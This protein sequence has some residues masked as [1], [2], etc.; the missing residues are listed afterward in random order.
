[1]SDLLSGYQSNLTVFHYQE[2]LN[3]VKIAVQ[4]GDYGGGKLF[5]QNSAFQLQEQGRDFSSLPLIP[6][7]SRATSESILYLFDLLRARY[8][9]ISQEKDDFVLRMNKLLSVIDKDTGLVDQ[10]LS[11]AEMETWV[12]SKPRLG[13]S[14]KFYLDFAE[15]HGIA[16]IS[17]LHTDPSTGNLGDSVIDASY[18]DGNR[19]KG[20]A[21]PAVEKT[22]SP[23]SL[24]WN[25]SSTGEVEELYSSDWTKLTSLEKTPLLQFGSPSVDVLFPSNASIR[26]VLEV[27]GSSNSGNLTVYVRVLF[28]PRRVEKK[29][30]F[31]AAGESIVLSPYAVD[32]FDMLILSDKAG[33]EQGVDYLLDNIGKLTAKTSTALQTLTVFFT[34]FYPA[35]QCSTNQADWS[36]L[37]HF[38][39]DRPFPDDI[40][41][42]FHLDLS[43]G[44][45][46]VL[47]ESANALGFFLRP[48]ANIPFECLFSLSTAALQSSGF[49][50]E[51]AIEFDRPEYLNGLHLNPFTNFPFELV[52][53][54]GENL[55]ANTRKIILDCSYQMNGPVTFRFPKQLLHR[56]FLHFQQRNYVLKQHVINPARQLRSQWLA[57]A[58]SVLPFSVRRLTPID[59]R[60][61]DGAQYEFGLNEIKGTSLELA[62]QNNP[63]V[64][65]SGPFHCSSLP[66]VIRFDAKFGAAVSCY[67]I[68][69]PYDSNNIALVS[70]LLSGYS[71]GY[72]LSDGQVISYPLPLAG[73][74]LTVDFYLKFVIRDA[75]SVVEKFLLQVSCV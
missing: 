56:V 70:R 53:I 11:A 48:L 52:R 19:T 47:D 5:D 51:L 36:P 12:A 61:V 8:S 68:D 74:A 15:S 69:K 58:Q 60:L 39:I 34:E 21:A 42:Y 63:G 17:I 41:Q 7:G 29:L 46:P 24:S 23:V 10:I 25:F 27:S 43:N 20:I 66:E 49:T 2:L 57:K 4:S 38:D 73:T 72:P 13:G 44:K 59:G 31:P 16:G 22:V 55:T 71:G 37:L 75:G 45:F 1:M 54:E 32:L 64:F 18:W 30:V 35:Y 6:A 40:Q 14:K 28:H 50:A 9:A 3:L 62:T 33:M 65:V 67:L 26:A